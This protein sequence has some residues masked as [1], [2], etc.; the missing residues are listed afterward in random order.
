MIPL[1]PRSTRNKV[2]VLKLTSMLL[3][4]GN[5]AAFEHGLEYP[6]AS[7]E[8]AGLGERER[9]RETER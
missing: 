5:P 6:A 3:E 9:E 4:V 8:P 7:W 2:V 1:S